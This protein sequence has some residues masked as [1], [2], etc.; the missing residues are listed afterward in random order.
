NPDQPVIP[1][2]VRPNCQKVDYLTTK[3]AKEVKDA[4]KKAFNDDIKA[5]LDKINGDMKALMEKHNRTESSVKQLIFAQTNYKNLT[6]VNLYNMLVYHIA[7][8]VNKDCTPGD[9]KHLKEIQQMASEELD[10]LTKQ[11]KNELHQELEG[12]CDLKTNSVRC[13]N[14]AANLDFQATVTRIGSEVTLLA[15]HTNCVAIAFFAPAHINNAT[16]PCWVHSNNGSQFIMDKFN[17]SPGEFSHRLEKWA[18]SHK[19]SD[20]LVTLQK[21]CTT[22]IVEGLRNITGQKGMKMCYEKYDAEIQYSHKV[23]LH[24]WPSNVKFAS[25]YKIT[26]MSNI[27]LLHDALKASKCTWVEMTACKHD[28]LKHKLKGKAAAKKSTA[29]RKRRE[30]D[31]NT[32]TNEHPPVK[33]VKKGTKSR[34]STAMLPPVF[35][36]APVI[37]SES[38]DD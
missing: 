1:P 4:N 36:S 2:N 14:A 25:P 23:Q 18:M 17:M 30:D 20:K 32:E 21:N 16:F 26:V 15:K 19:S 27:H 38:K 24:G 8:E 22:I 7:V 12:F 6:K 37:E 35:R 28:N 33:K 34:K 31:E 13:N 3:I 5:L 9:H 29:K 10:K 11:E